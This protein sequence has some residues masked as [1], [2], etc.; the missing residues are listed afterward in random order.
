[1]KCQC[2]SPP[3]GGTVAENGNPPTEE[4]F[5]QRE[6]QHTLLTID[7]FTPFL[8]IVKRIFICTSN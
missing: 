4:R 7:Y 2:R 6:K 8:A 3:R 1:M 5:R